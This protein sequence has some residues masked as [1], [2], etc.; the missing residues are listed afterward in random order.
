MNESNF[1][2]D[3]TVPLPG[4]TLYTR[5]PGSFPSEVSPLVFSRNAAIVLS[6]RIEKPS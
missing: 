6:A 4:R 2:G 1:G 5:T 3:A